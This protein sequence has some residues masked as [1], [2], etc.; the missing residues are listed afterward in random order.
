MSTWTGTT[1]L[2]AMLLLGSACRREDQPEV[3]PVVQTLTPESREGL[4]RVLAD[5][6]RIQRALAADRL[7]G[8]AA[9]AMS[10]ALA[11]KGLIP[12]VPVRLREPLNG[13]TSAAQQ[14]AASTMI[15]DARRAFGD[16]SRHAIALVAEAPELGEGRRA[17][18]CTMASGYQKWIQS[19]PGIAN[20]Y[21]GSEMLTCGTGSDWK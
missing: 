14:V 15:A 18:E 10:L 16:L 21:F 13:L 8:V 5:Y 4:E 1:T 7:D 19:G 2:L 17:F 11:A 3:A 12:R 9:A 20:P 6:D